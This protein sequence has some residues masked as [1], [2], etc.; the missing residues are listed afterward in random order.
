MDR[1]PA[2]LLRVAP[3]FALA[4]FGACAGPASE[5]AAR[6]DPAE[7]SRSSA[8]ADS[9]E[10]D[11]AL[12]ADQGVCQLWVLKR[13][14]VFRDGTGD[15]TCDPSHSEL[16]GNCIGDSALCAIATRAV[17]ASS[18]LT[19]VAD[20]LRREGF[21]V[22]NHRECPPRWGPAPVTNP[23]GCDG[24]AAQTGFERS[25]D[26]NHRACATDADCVAVH[27]DCSNA[28]CTGVHRRHAGG[29]RAPLSCDGYNGPVTDYDCR[30][31]PM[32]CESGCCVIRTPPPPPCSR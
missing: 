11:C 1:A 23:N 19:Q 29:Y 7:T 4:V 20:F 8:P 10:L 16:S 14:G 5:G 25:V 2:L 30:S 24:F 32:A 22:Q 18:T 12:E 31:E 26:G 6:P 17:V 21:R 9:S 28:L 15:G 27:L 13:P 3:I